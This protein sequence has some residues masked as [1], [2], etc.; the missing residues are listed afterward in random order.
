MKSCCHTFYLIVAFLMYIRE[1]C[2]KDSMYFS[3][4]SKCQFKIHLFQKKNNTLSQMRTNSQHSTWHPE[5]IEKILYCP[6]TILVVIYKA[7]L[8]EKK[9]YLTFIQFSQE[10]NSPFLQWCLKP[11]EQLELWLFTLILNAFSKACHFKEEMLNIDKVQL[12]PQ[13]PHQAAQ[14]KIGKKDNYF[15][16]AL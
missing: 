10:K 11:T 12:V 7:F 15:P 5:E 4:M 14:T 6:S 9:S 1:A 13:L 2:L 3:V 16:T 8:Q